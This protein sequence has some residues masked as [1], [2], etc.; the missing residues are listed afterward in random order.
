M[1]QDGKKKNNLI[2]W[3]SLLVFG[4]TSGTVKNFQAKGQNN[5]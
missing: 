1:E 5:A 2:Y 4:Y 3:F